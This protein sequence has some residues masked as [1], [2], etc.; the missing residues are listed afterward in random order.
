MNRPSK[1]WL[2]L[3]KAALERAQ[4]TAIDPLSPLYTIHAVVSVCFL[5]GF[6][7]FQ[8]FDPATDLNWF[9]TAQLLVVFIC[10]VLV[11]LLTGS[12]FTLHFSNLKL[13]KLLNEAEL[14]H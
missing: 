3:R 5:A 7:R 8:F 12:V 10:G 1:N 6:L 2:S 11:P 13:E 4:R 14:R 9:T